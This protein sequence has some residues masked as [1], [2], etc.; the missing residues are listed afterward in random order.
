MLCESQRPLDTCNRVL[1]VVSDTF[2][3]GL[4]NWPKLFDP[5]KTVVLGKSQSFWLPEMPLK[6]KSKIFHYSKQ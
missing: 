3:V 1:F 6:N 5:C 4:C 2:V